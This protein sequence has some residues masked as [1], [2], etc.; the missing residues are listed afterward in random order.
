MKKNK[1]QFNRFKDTAW[2]D[3]NC[4]KNIFMIEMLCFD[5][6][7]YSTLEEFG[8]FMKAEETINNHQMHKLIPFSTAQRKPCMQNF[9]TNSKWKLA[10]YVEKHR[11]C[12]ANVLMS[13]KKKEMLF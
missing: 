1:R 11:N 7:I 6:R 13:R 9:K 12:K 4:N 10:E 2:L 8:Q 3:I 5:I